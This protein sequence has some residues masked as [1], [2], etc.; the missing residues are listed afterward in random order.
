MTKGE[1]SGYCRAV[2]FGGWNRSGA[3]GVALFLAHLYPNEAL[4]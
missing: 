3:I 1:V 2:A 4:E